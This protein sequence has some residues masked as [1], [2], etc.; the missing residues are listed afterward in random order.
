MTEQPAKRT[1]IRAWWPFPGI[2]FALIGMSMTM[3][4]VTVVL[5]TN[6]PS[7]G[8]EED[9][10]AKAVAWDET[11]EQTELNA[12]LGWKA[13][14]TLAADLDGRGD[15][16]I[17]VLLMDS[18]G[19]AVEGAT[20]EA[21]CFHNARRRETFEFGFTEIAPG[22]YSAGQPMVR[23]GRW[24]VRLRATVGDTVFTHTAHTWTKVD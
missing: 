15:R 12:Q 24:T 13:D 10:F 20:F 14:V 7:F 6:D 5:A 4:T 3:A 11:A 9:Y 23:D 21:F 19:K 22:R 17:T 8:L 2:V 18:D 16:S 1:G